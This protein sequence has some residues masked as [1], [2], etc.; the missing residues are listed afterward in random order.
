MPNPGAGDRKMVTVSVGAA[1]ATPSAE[2]RIEKLVCCADIALY[3]AKDDGRNLIIGHHDE[4]GCLD[5][6]TS[7]RQGIQI[8]LISSADCVACRG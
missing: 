4:M 2:R 6:I 8:P 1:C 5:V 3:R 7:R